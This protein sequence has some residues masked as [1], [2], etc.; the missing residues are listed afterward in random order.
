MKTAD[1]SLGS[2]TLESLFGTT[3]T[4]RDSAFAISYVVTS[5]A[6]QG[7]TLKEVTVN[8][9]WTAPPK[10]STASATTLVHQQF[11]GPRGSSLVM[12]PTQTDTLGSPFLAIFNA[13]NGFQPATTTA[14]LYIAQADWA[15]IFYDLS[16][17]APTAHV[18]MRLGAVDDDGQSI[19][20][21]PSA[22]DYKIGTSYVHYSRDAGG[23]IDNVWFEYAFNA[24]SLPDGYWEMQAV[25]FN[26]Y[27]EPGNTWRLRLR[28]EKGAPAKP[29][30]FTAIPQAD[31][32]TIVLNWA[33]GA[34][35]DRSFWVLQ[36]RK[37]DYSTNSWMA[38]GTVDESI[39][40]KL[41]TYTDVG[42][43]GSGLDPWGNASTQNYYQYS[44]WAVDIGNPGLAGASVQAQTYIPPAVTTTTSTP[45]STSSTSSTTSS[46]TTSTT[47]LYSVN[48]LNNSSTSYS[49][50]IKNSL[51]TTVY[52]GTAKKNK[53]LTVSGLAYGPYQISATAGSKVIPGSF[54]AGSTPN[55]V[56]TIQ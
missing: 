2:R 40:P 38:W 22:S 55:P 23:A 16:Q 8:V 34:E 19:A 24:A 33:S 56:F 42:N 18:Y 48:I 39:D 7:G 5:Q 6:Y 17:A 4:V 13:G 49:I 20:L 52:T 47:T 21:G 11:L 14:K 27:N 45:T 29:T 15:L 51:G 12:T 31:N 35:R 44:L 53:T 9:G 25:A 3:E 41:T 46:S 50:A 28:V 1:P 36:R 10:V 32:H 37:W 54:T 30:S 43:V 26:E